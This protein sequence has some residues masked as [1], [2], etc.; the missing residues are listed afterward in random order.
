M[1]NRIK[2]RTDIQG[3][4]PDPASPGAR[5]NKKRPLVD[6]TPGDGE[7]SISKQQQ[8][9]IAD[10]FPA[11]RPKPPARQRPGHSIKMALERGAPDAISGT[12]INE[13]K[14]YNFSRHLPYLVACVDPTLTGVKTPLPAARRNL[15]ANLK[16]C[17]GT[18]AALMICRP[19]H[20]RIK[21]LTAACQKSVKSFC[22]QNLQF[23]VLQAGANDVRF[24]CDSAS[25]KSKW[26]GDD[27]LHAMLRVNHLDMRDEQEAILAYYVSAMLFVG[28]DVRQE[29]RCSRVSSCTR[30]TSC[31]HPSG[32]YHLLYS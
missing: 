8:P 11:A 26:R 1:D 2:S 6:D 12:C 15:L 31:W 4:W 32:R 14:A 18:L 5:A 7:C 13:L 3:A 23:Y 9:A 24:L 21:N 17:D 16:L 22:R 27:S 28:K 25:A 10:Y 29:W 30:W 20:S 19:D